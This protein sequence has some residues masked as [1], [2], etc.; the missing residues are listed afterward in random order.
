MV[1]DLIL[2]LFQEIFLIL[3]DFTLEDR[4]VVIQV[5]GLVLDEPIFNLAILYLRDIDHFQLGLVAVLATFLNLLQSSDE[6]DEHIDHDEHDEQ[7][8][9][10]DLVLENSKVGEVKPQTIV[11]RHE[12]YHEY[13]ED[14]PNVVYRVRV[15]QFV[16]EIPHEDAIDDED[17][18]DAIVHDPH[19]LE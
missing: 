9:E 2:F 5:M 15:G 19:S 7:G 6:G 18:V 3:P 1:E 11:Q 12:S 8:G 10:H 14:L 13:V 17:V 16:I 4:L